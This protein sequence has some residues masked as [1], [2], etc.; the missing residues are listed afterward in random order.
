M[1]ISNVFNLHNYHDSVDMGLSMLSSKSVPSHAEDSEG[2]Y[3]SS[4]RRRD[5]V[6]LE[7]Q[8]DGVFMGLCA[9][10]FPVT[11][12]VMSVCV[13]MSCTLMVCVHVPEVQKVQ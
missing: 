10:K 7:L 2:M 12:V 8:R 5:L 13:S 6:G 11:M 1:C 4:S 9:S 3:G